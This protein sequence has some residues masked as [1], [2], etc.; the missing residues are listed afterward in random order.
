MTID[1]T[2]VNSVLH[3]PS[4][5][6]TW[7]HHMSCSTYVGWLVPSYG[8]WWPYQI[9][10][11]S[12]NNGHDQLLSFQS[13]VTFRLSFLHSVTVIQISTIL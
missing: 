5:F 1:R 8:I 4:T 7:I 2:F 3:G 11:A 10:K 13:S 12:H 9:Q 6:L